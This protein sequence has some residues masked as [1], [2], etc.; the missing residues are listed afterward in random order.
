MPGKDEREPTSA[1]DAQDP[2]RLQDDVAYEPDAERVRQV[3]D[4]TIGSWSDVDLDAMI[5]EIDAARR[6]GSRP[7][8]RP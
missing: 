5:A 6:A 8:D 7:P 4:E 3:L 1:F 2:S